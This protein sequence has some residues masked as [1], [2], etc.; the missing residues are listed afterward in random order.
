MCLGGRTSLPNAA[1][2]NPLPKSSPKN[3]SQMGQLKSHSSV[4]KESDALKSSGSSVRPLDRT[5][6]GLPAALRAV[7]AFHTP[8]NAST[9][10]SM[11]L[12]AI[13]R[14]LNRYIQSLEMTLGCRFFLFCESLKALKTLRRSPAA[15]RLVNRVLRQYY[16]RAQFGCRCGLGLRKV[17]GCVSI[18]GRNLD[19]GLGSMCH[20]C[21]LACWR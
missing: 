14:H 13:F 16:Q 3:V 20:C 2:P 6:R 18:C 11:S 12:I 21:K 4:G 10:G 17:F 15:K 7:F 8:T 5:E 9:N 19:F 1:R